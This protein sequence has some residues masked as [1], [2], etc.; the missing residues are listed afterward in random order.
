MGSNSSGAESDIKQE[1]LKL[2]KLWP[3]QPNKLIFSIQ[4]LLFCSIVAS[5]DLNLCFI[6]I[7]SVWI[8]FTVAAAGLPLP[9]HQGHHDVLQLIPYIPIPTVLLL[10]S[11]ATT[12]VPPWGLSTPPCNTWTCCSSLKAPSISRPEFPSCAPHYPLYQDLNFSLSL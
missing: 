4:F 10:I 8:R 12:P 7:F 6:N 9:Q 11:P 1:V 2:A 3:S 5:V